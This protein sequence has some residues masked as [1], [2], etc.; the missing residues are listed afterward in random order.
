M[1][2]IPSWNLKHPPRRSATSMNLW[3][4]LPVQMWLV[5]TRVINE[6]TAYAELMVEGVVLSRLQDCGGM[7][8]PAILNVQVKSS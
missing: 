2:C 1:P 4:E 6:L 7:I 5:V 8:Q 3:S